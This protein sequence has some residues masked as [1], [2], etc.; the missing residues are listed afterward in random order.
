MSE[1]KKLFH[2]WEQRLAK[3]GLSKRQLDVIREPGLYDRDNRWHRWKKQ[4]VQSVAREELVRFHE[5]AVESYPRSGHDWAN[6]DAAVRTLLLY[7]YPHLLS[8]PYQRERASLTC[9]LIYHY[10]RLCEPTTAIA[11]DLKMPVKTVDVRIERIK[12]LAT[13]L[14]DAGRL[15]AAA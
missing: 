7:L 8:Q 1:S 5:V 3:Y 9:S 11:Y 15:L 4:A 10:F 6:S 2:K 13:S 12:R 14:Q